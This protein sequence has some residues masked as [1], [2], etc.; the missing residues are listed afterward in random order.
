VYCGNNPLVIIDLYGEDWYD[1]GG[2]HLEW[3]EGSDPQLKPGFW[4]WLKSLAGKGEY[5]ESLGKNVLFAKGSL[6]EKVNEAVFELY[7]ESNKEGPVATIMGNTVPSDQ[8]EYATMAEGPYSAELTNFRDNPALLI[9]EGGKVPTVFPNPNPESA[10]YGQN[11]ANGIYFHGG[12]KFREDVWSLP[13]RLGIKIPIS[14]GC[15]TA[16]HGNLQK[17]KNFM[18]NFYSNWIGSYYLIRK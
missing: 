2:N 4:N 15:Q 14:K 16:S 3:R 7:S 13:N 6:D 10:Y 11:F 9:N 12:N 17:Y 8:T 18:E 1:L 5:A